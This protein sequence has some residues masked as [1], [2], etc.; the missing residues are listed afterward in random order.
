LTLKGSL[1]SHRV[2]R[3]LRESGFSQ[4]TQEIAYLAPLG[5]CNHSVVILLC[6]LCVLER[7]ERAGERLL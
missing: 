4:D 5:A 7:S 3:V 2:H 6:D 1:T